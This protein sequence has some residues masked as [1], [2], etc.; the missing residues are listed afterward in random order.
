MTRLET[1]RD[2]ETENIVI[3]T[4]NPKNNIG[5]IVYETYIDFGMLWVFD[6]M[7]TK[8]IKDLTS[9]FPRLACNKLIWYYNEI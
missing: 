1:Y 8:L 3:H 9:G 7:R 2:A 6:V 5:I 4:E